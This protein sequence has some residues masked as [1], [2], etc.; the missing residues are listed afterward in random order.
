MQRL[1][2]RRGGPIHDGGGGKHACRR[3]LQGGHEDSARPRA[4]YRSRGKAPH[5]SQPAHLHTPARSLPRSRS[6][7]RRCRL[8]FFLRVRCLRRLTWRPGEAAGPGARGQVLAQGVAA[9]TLCD[10]S[11]PRPTSPRQRYRYSNAR[12]RGPGVQPR[13]QVRCVTRC[14][15]LEAEA[16]GQRHAPGA[17][18]ARGVGRRIFSMWLPWA[19]HRRR[20]PGAPVAAADAGRGLAPTEIS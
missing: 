1:G 8:R 20:S 15:G 11:F 5:L 6:S 16:C 9:M 19:P 7:T 3:W 17:L 10:G 2:R 18:I 12:R 4:Q 13:R 14:M